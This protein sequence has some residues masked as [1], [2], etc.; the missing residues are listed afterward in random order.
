MSNLKQFKQNIDSITYA[1]VLKIREQKQNHSLKL[2]DLEID[3]LK[4]DEYVEVIR[5]FLDALG[6]SH[7][8][9]DA[10]E[11]R[12]RDGYFPNSYNKGGLEGLCYRDEQSACQNTG[13]KE[14]DRI[15]QDSYD[16]NFKAYCIDNKL[17]LSKVNDWT[18]EQ[19]EAW[20]ESEQDYMQDSTI[21]FQA[22]VMFT[23][24]TTANVDFYVS[25][26]D[27]PYHRSSDDK[28]ELKIEFKSTAGLR[29]KLN[30]ILKKDFVQCFKQNVRE[31]F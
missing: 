7:N 23:S 5:E 3:L 20:Y 10:F 11:C 17:D 24:E 1:D 30:A 19:R 29:R 16:Y 12:R 2:E 18:D 22:R 28:L 4:A 31:G 27:S 6:Y 25:A 26:S 9:I 8:R 13:F 21:Q 15:L 14:T